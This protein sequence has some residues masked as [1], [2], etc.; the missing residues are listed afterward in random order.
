MTIRVGSATEGFQTLN[1]TSTVRLH[2]RAGTAHGEHYGFPGRTTGPGGQTDDPLSGAPAFSVGIHAVG[3]GDSARTGGLDERHVQT[4]AEIDGPFPPI[5][6]HAATMRVVDG[7]HR[8]AAAERRGDTHIA[9]VYFHGT[10]EEAFRVGVSANT[11]HG[12]PLSRAERRSA[13][14]RIIG[15]HPHL[16]DRAI[17]ESAGLSHTTV[18][19]IRKAALADGAH[20]GGDTPRV[21]ADG[22]VR[23]L[24]VADGRLAAGMIIAQRP[25]ASLRTV[26]REA[27]ISVGTAR[28]VR[29]RVLE[30]RSPLPPREARKQA[31][32][33]KE[34]GAVADPPPQ[35]VDA[36]VMFASLRRDPMLRYTDSGRLLLRWLDQSMA[37]MTRWNEVEGQIPGHCVDKIVKIARECSRFWATIADQAAHVDAETGAM[38]RDATSLSA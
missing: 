1:R 7:A 15:S 26:A 19:K 20:T 31:T 9:A 29:L 30:G 6:L 16:S 32:F 23:P 27:G 35:V 34:R 2:N 12:L 21:G 37:T 8:L 10:R 4:L 3:E 36:G 13:A 28:D 38:G 11:A 14:L 22:R 17:A 25:E 33:A 24:S 18:A 5:V